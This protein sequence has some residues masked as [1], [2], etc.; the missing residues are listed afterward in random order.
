[1]LRGRREG[2]AVPPFVEITEWTL[3][4]INRPVWAEP[5]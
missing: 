4:P 1:M 5:A 2:M 3:P